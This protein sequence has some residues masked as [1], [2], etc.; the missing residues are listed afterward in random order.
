MDANSG[1]PG[2]KWTLLSLRARWISAGHSPR[3]RAFCAGDEDQVR[4]RGRALGLVEHSGTRARVVR[5]AASA[6]GISSA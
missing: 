6:S 1:E 3:L 5:Y 4:E 2:R